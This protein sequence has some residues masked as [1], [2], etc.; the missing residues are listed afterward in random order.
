MATHLPPEKVAI[1]YEMIEGLRPDGKPYTNLDIMQRVGC[2]EAAVRH[3]RE[4]RRKRLPTWIEKRDS[5]RKLYGDGVRIIDIVKTCHTSHEKVKAAVADLPARRRRER[6]SRDK[7]M[8]IRAAYTR[9]DRIAAIEALYSV[10]D[11]TIRRVTKGLP[12]RTKERDGVDMKKCVL[13]EVHGE[14]GPYMVQPTGKME[15]CTSALAV[16]R[17]WHMEVVDAR[18]GRI[19]LIPMAEIAVWAQPVQNAPSI[20]SQKRVQHR[21]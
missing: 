18:D 20:T 12:R 16:E 3:Y 17:Q 21:A 8:G 9:G 1:I 15:F 2:S 14:A 10:S 4:G 5:I 7:V 13:I 6:L 11:G 19:K